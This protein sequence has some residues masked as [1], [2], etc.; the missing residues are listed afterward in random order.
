MRK[1][2]PYEEEY[3]KHS[4]FRATPDSDSSGL[5]L[6][7]WLLVLFLVVLVVLGID[8]WRKRPQTQP[9]SFTETAEIPQDNALPPPVAKIAKRSAVEPPPGVEVRIPPPEP[10]EDVTE[11]SPPAFVQESSAQPKAVEPAPPR[12][13]ETMPEIEARYEMKMRGNHFVGQGEIN[14]KDVTLMADT[15][16]STVVVPER[17]AQRLGLKKGPPLPFHTAGGDVT[18]FA[19]TLEKLTLG[20]IEISNVSAV[21]SPTMNVDFVLLG[22][23]ALKLMDMEYG[24]QMLVLK[25]KQ[26]NVSKEMRTVDEEEFKRS[27]K[28]CAS[29]GNKFDKQTL[30]CLRGQ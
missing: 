20:R 19:T 9:P 28:D 11:V 16:A 29:H 4:S 3:G 17:M 30:D 22:M 1:K 6:G 5:P 14:G 24:S 18:H 7:R 2:T 26:M 13:E 25:H 15:G 23:S 27:V 8:R 12:L 21:I 10:T